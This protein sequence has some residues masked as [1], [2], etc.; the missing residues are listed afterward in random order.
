MAAYD[1]TTLRIF[2]DR[3]LR[4][5]AALVLDDFSSSMRRR[6]AEAG[7]TVLL[8]NGRDGEWRAA[9]AERAGGIVVTPLA[10]TR[11]QPAQADLWCLVSPPRETTTMA[12]QA[13]SAVE[14]GVGR[15]VPVLS[16]HG[17]SPPA[18]DWLQEV[19][20]D[21]AARCGV[22]AIPEIAAPRPLADVLADWPADRRLVFCDEEAT[23]VD[24]PERLAALAAVPLAVLIGPEHGLAEEERAALLALPGAVRLW[25]GPR[26][27]SADVALVAALTLVQ[28]ACGKA[29]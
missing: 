10:Q 24:T 20:V 6:L 26:V 28:A 12:I 7:D 8:F 15:L 2:V 25:L 9:V 19:V 1:F 11:P 14:M 23:A 16:R 13:R 21:A 17:G 4:V 18:A 27:L 5:G 3:P 22:L 29:S